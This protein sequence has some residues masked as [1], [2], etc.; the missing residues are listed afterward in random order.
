[1]LILEGQTGPIRR[2]AFAPDGRHLAAAASGVDTLWVWS[3]PGCEAE[4]LLHDKGWVRAL[5]FALGGVTLAAV[6]QHILLCW[7]TRQWDER[8][9]SPLMNQGLIALGFTA[10]GGRLR[11]AVT[12]SSREGDLLNLHERDAATGEERRSFTSRLRGHASQVV[13]VPGH[14]SLVAVTFARVGMSLWGPAAGTEQLAFPKGT[15][16]HSVSF[17]PDGRTLA[18]CGL[19]AGRVWSLNP[20]R[21]RSAF[22]EKRDVHALI[23]S[24]DS[25][26]VATAGNAGT[27]NLWD[28]ATGRLRLALD[29]GVGRVTALAFAPDGMTAAAGGETGK[30]AVWD[31]E[32]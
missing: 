30:I 4:I 23:W 11:A 12:R 29:P 8:F 26:T 10:D 18:T 17:S 9:Q 25:R 5:A 27:V 16:I 6:H 13:F 24:P 7:E 31:V 21:Q 2:L 20:F 22:S 28:P 15:L 19:R 14:R 1:L 32:V 3:L